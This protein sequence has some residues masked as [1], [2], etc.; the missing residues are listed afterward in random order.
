MPTFQFFKEGKKMD[1]VKG[2]DVQQLTTKIG[3]YTAAAAKA[4]ASGPGTK[5]GESKPTASPTAPGSLRSC[6]DIAASKLVNTSNL[7]SVRNIAS[8]PPA[9]YAVASASG[10]RMLVHLVFT[11]AVTP[12]HIRISVPADSMSSAPSRINVGS[13]VAPRVVRSSD[14]VESSGFDME[15]LDRAENTQSFNIYSDEYVNGTAE[16]KL[17]AS[18]FTAV[19]S[20]TI[21][22]DAN[23]SGEDTVVSKVKELDIIGVKA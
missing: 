19:N 4:S 7:S 15:S 21:R 1:E 16:L 20:L 3:Y 12:S 14:G 11:Q 10:P 22:V 8:P 9:G 13:N 6:I 5:A 18:K 17:K 23:L 2:A